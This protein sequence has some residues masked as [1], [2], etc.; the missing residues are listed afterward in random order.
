MCMNTIKKYELDLRV[1]AV[2][3]LHERYVQLRLTQDEPLP[4]ML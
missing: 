3:C 1:T 4:P 2:V